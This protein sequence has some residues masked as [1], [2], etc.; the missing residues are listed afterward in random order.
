MCP[1][2]DDMVIDEFEV[3]V[4]IEAFVEYTGRCPAELDVV[5]LDGA[6]E[7]VAVFVVDAFLI[8]GGKEWEVPGRAVDGA[9]DA[10]LLAVGVE[11]VFLIARD[12]HETVVAAGRWLAS[13][14]GL[15][16]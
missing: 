4:E 1:Y 7:V 3:F 9:H 14:F 5:P 8:V 12:L 15:E 10:H 13:F 2:L 6:M 11:A 16:E